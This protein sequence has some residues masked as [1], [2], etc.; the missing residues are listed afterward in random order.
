VRALGGVAAVVVLL[1]LTSSALAAFPGGNGLLAVQP[2]AG[3]GIILVSA[4]GRG[5]RRVCVSRVQCGTPRRPRWSPDGRAL[6]FAGPAIKIIYTDGSCLNCQLGAGSNPAF[7]PGGA[8]ISLIAHDRVTVDKID[9]LPAGSQP[10]ASA[11]DA[12]WSATG[13]LAVVRGGAIW[14]GV[15]GRLRR[16]GTGTEPSWSPSGAMIAAVQRGWIVILGV[17][18]HRA[19]R[20]VRGSS[21]AFSPDGRLIAYVAPGHGLMI[22]QASGAAAVP[23]RSDGSVATSTNPTGGTRAWKVSELERQGFLNAVFCS[24]RPDCFVSDNVTGKVFTSTDPT[25]GASAWTLSTSTPPFQSGACPTTSLCVAVNGQK[26][27]QTTTSPRAGTWTKQ[28]AA[29]NLHAVACP[30]AALCLAVGAAGALDISTNPASG[31]WTQTTIDDGR[32]L[33]SIACPS[34]TLCVTA[35]LTG[36][37]V[38][39]TDPTGGSSMWSSALVQDQCTANTSCSVEQI[40]AS[41]RSGLHTVDFTEAPG[42]GPFLTGLTLTGDVLSWSHDGTPRTVTLTP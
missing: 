32:E 16:I 4:T 41:D 13:E 8:V 12:V 18:N 1:W 21:P 14:A 30:S 15:P 19:R 39:S 27:I 20:L 10:P 22:A 28:A 38:T 5:E 17:R 40:Q 6:V 36:D 2:Q 33:T 31:V 34:A 26:N 7:K 9:G 29:E 42:N 24:A 11:S 37:I 25:A 35:D 23:R 3:K